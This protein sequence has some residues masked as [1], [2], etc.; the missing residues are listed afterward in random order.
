MLTSNF[1]TKVFQNIDSGFAEMS[2]L[3]SA[4]IDSLWDKTDVTLM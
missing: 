4:C 2:E 1:G 3:V